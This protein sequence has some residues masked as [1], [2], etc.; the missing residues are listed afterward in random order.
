MG[1]FKDV[2]KVVK[3]IFNADDDMVFDDER[4]FNDNF[5]QDN[6]FAFPKP[7]SK[8]SNVD[9]SGFSNN[10]NVF[11]IEN[12]GFDISKMAAQNNR[13]NRNN[14][15]IQLY[16]PKNFDESFGIIK[17]IKN[18]FTAIVNVEVANQQIGQ[19]IIDVI[20]GA[21][22]ALDGDC[23]KM[24]EKQY[25]FSLSTETIGAYD[26][27]SFNNGPSNGQP[28]SGFNFNMRPNY[29]FANQQPN[30]QNV[31]PFSQP[32]SFNQFINN[33]QN[34]PQQ[35]MNYGQNVER[36]SYDLQGFYEPPKSQF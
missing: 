36:M 6:S 32:Q 1:I 21:M 2:S 8:K 9:N 11:D 20:S 34:N 30:N 5:R 29:D 22:Y 7:F 12:R 14:G 15:K 19:R 17:D 10:K 13:N 28:L 35:G 31:N 4:E 18:G 33:N 24:G 16:V 23:K 25:I 3:S 26:F 27:L